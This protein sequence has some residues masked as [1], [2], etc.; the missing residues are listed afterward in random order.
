MLTRESLRE[1]IY[2]YLICRY[3]SLSVITEEFISNMQIRL[4]EEKINFEFYCFLMFKYFEFVQ[5]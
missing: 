3:N 5:I 2:I 1:Y 4:T